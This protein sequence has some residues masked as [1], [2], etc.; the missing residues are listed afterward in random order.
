MDEYGD[1]EVGNKK[2]DAAFA[3]AKDFNEV[4]GAIVNY[5]IGCF[6]LYP[7]DPTPWIILRTLNEYGFLM[8]L[9]H[10]DRVFVTTSYFNSVS[11][12]DPPPTHPQR[13]TC[14]TVTGTIR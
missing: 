2:A 3:E 1:V 9:P 10:R 12:T 11:D 13:A 4:L 7:A 5:G 14:F 6:E 8:H